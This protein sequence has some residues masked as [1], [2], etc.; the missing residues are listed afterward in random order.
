LNQ[1][2]KQTTKLKT[3]IITTTCHDCKLSRGT[4]EN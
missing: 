4:T 2:F 1:K 3:T